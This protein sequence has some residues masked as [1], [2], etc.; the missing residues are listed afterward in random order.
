MTTTSSVPLQDRAHSPH[1]KWI[2]AIGVFKLLEAT[3]FIL[4]GI[5]AIR[6]LHKDLIDVTEHFILA[7]RFDPEGRFVNLILDKVALIDPHRLKQ[8]SAA[9]FCIA[10]LHIVEGTGLVMEKAWAEYVTLILTASFLPF[11]F[12]EIVRHLTW[13]K[14]ALT[15]INVAVLIYLLYYVKGRMRERRERLAGGV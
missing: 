15:T 10:G 12:F 14:V 7:L 9:V 4:L 13:I 2:M 11:E 8:I 5:G 6:L 1:D 3:L